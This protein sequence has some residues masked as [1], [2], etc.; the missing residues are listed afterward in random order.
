MKLL[1]IFV[2]LSKSQKQKLI[3]GYK[4]R[5]NVNV[6]VILSNEKEGNRIFVTKT[7]YNKITKGIKPVVIT[8]NEHIINQ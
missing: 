8:F 3:R 6:K 7:Q 2:K 4:K 1:P 5:E